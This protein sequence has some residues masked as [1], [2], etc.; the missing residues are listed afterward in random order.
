MSIPSIHK[1]LWAPRPRP[2]PVVQQLELDL[3]VP[4]RRDS[5]RDTA[6]AELRKLRESLAQG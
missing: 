2:R 3:G 5:S 4:A 1:L 6:A